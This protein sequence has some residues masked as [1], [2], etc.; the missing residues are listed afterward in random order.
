MDGKGED[1]DGPSD[2]IV[3][4][5]AGASF[6]GAAC[7]YLAG[8]SATARAWTTPSYSYVRNWISDLGAT[9]VGAFHGR[10][11]SSPLHAV[12]NAAFLVDGIFFL[13]GA[14]MLARTAAGP[15]ARLFLVF[16]VAHSL[17]MLLVGLVPETVSPPLGSLHLLGAM[18]AIG[19][20]NAAIIVGGRLA[21]LRWAGLLLGLFGLAAF[22]ALAFPA[23]TAALGSGL[24]E[25]L[26]VYPITLWELLAGLAL[27]SPSPAAA[28]RRAG[29]AT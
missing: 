3:R 26:A 9:G 12:M 16:A 23:A 2:R 29:P 28:A 7:F 20:G 17:G 25:R 18:L 24:V 10:S 22:A 21:G 4:T 14:I 19:G 27:L 8:E 11:L 15:R 1:R 13:L 5:R 6:M